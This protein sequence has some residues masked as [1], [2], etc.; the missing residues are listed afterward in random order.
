[1]FS[2]SLSEET[3]TSEIHFWWT[4]SVPS[5]PLLALS[6]SNR[7][8]PV[9]QLID[10]SRR[11]LPSGPVVGYSAQIPIWRHVAHKPIA[12]GDRYRPQVLAIW[13]DEN[14]LKV[15][16]SE[17]PLTTRTRIWL[18]TTAYGLLE[19]IFWRYVIE[20]LYKI[21]LV[22]HHSL[23]HQKGGDH[24][25]HN[26]KK[27]DKA[28]NIILWGIVGVRRGEGTSL[29]GFTGFNHDLVGVEVW[30][31]GNAVTAQFVNGT[32]RGLIIDQE[33]SIQVLPSG[34]ARIFRKFDAALTDA[35][36]AKIEEGWG[37]GW[38]GDDESSKKRGYEEQ[39]EG[40]KRK[41]HCFR[42]WLFDLVCTGCFLRK[43]C[44]FEKE[45]GHKSAKDKEYM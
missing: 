12:C 41:M 1:M 4:F 24:K 3:T 21:E 22:D 23:I 40:R 26:K 35:T 19:L 45:V 20:I 6:W 8:L 28:Y 7:T 13:L 29:S 11:P 10:V 44:M 5:L 17:I 15:E 39:F 36:L 31:V 9:N 2:T 14:I 18:I 42:S 33:V 32:I 25:K 38:S 37:W 34:A 30:W 16:A 27:I 43:G